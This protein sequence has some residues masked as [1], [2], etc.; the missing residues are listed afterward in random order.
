M[1][2]LTVVFDFYAAAEQRDIVQTI[3]DNYNIASTGRAEWYRFQSPS[4]PLAP[5]SQTSAT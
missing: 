4:A 5:Q 2:N 1:N 3:V